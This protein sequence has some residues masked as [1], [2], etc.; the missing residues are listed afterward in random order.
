MMIPVGIST[1]SELTA[2]LVLCL[3]DCLLYQ[4][5]NTRYQELPYHG[6]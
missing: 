6:M 2:L 1:P 5:D 4:L 3:I